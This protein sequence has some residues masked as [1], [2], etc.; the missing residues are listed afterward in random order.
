M[1]MSNQNSSHHWVNHKMVIN[2]V[3]GTQTLK[4]K[5]PDLLDVPNQSFMP[6]I[7]EMQNQRLDYIV[8]VSRILVEYFTALSHFKDSVLQHIPH[9]YSKEMSKQ[10]TKV[11]TFHS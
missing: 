5:Q 11:N 9:K 7:T 10:S 4:K 3:S 6:S 8:L 2:R 1:T